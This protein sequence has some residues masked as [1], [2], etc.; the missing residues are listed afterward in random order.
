MDRRQ[1]FDHSFKDSEIPE[2]QHVCGKTGETAST[3][4]F[5]N[6]RLKDNWLSLNTTGSAGVSKKDKCECLKK[7]RMKK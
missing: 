7:V 6:V 1:K 4:Q 5:P 2:M 3:T